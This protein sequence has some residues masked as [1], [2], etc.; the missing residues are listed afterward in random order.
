M[1][2][3]QHEKFPA[4]KDHSHVVLNQKHSSIT[5]PE[6]LLHLKIAASYFRKQYP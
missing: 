1:P 3:E 4:C 6:K 5:I 2:Q